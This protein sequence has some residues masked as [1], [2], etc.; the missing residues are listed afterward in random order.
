[1]T[2][3]GPQSFQASFKPVPPYAKYQA[4]AVQFNALGTSKAE[5]R[6]LF[7]AYK[8]EAKARGVTPRSGSTRDT[9]PGFTA[10]P[11]TA[12]EREHLGH[13]RTFAQWSA[14]QGLE[15]VTESPRGRQ[16]G[17]VTSLSAYPSQVWV[18][19]P[20][21]GFYLVHKADLDHVPD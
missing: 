16:V 20:E 12:L 14:F 1:M 9:R 3:T 13:R 4:P 7:A 10:K 18:F 11:F 17:V 21:V 5:Q 2:L 6:E 15:G 19:V 8:A